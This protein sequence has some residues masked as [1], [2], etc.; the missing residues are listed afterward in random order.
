MS[1]GK[2]KYS[3]D[4]L[5]PDIT[6]EKNFRKR[7][8]MINKYISEWEH[9]TGTV[10]GFSQVL[11]EE[12]EQ[13]SFYVEEYNTLI[14]ELFYSNVSY[15]DDLITPDIKN[16]WAKDLK[17]QLEF[18]LANNGEQGRGYIKFDSKHFAIIDDSKFDYYSKY[19]YFSKVVFSFLFEVFNEVN[20]ARVSR[21]NQ[22]VSKKLIFEHNLKSIDRIF[23]TSTVNNRTKNNQSRIDGIEYILKSQFYLNDEFKEYLKNSIYNLAA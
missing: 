20:G 4:S 10:Y 14:N 5:A 23:T 21:V 15:R 22:F 17:S 8:E 19:I 18:N 7:D 6:N 2:Y 12:V 1:E 3:H 13:H 9:K 11:V 16:S